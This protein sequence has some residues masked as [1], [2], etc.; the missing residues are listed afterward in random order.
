MVCRSRAKFESG[1]V[2]PRQKLRFE[3]KRLTAM[4]ARIAIQLEPC[5]PNG[6]HAAATSWQY[7][8]VYERNSFRFKQLDRVARH[9]ELLGANW[10][11]SSD[12]QNR[13]RPHL[14]FLRATRR[15]QSGCGTL[16]DTE[17]QKTLHGKNTRRKY[18][19]G[20]ARQLNDLPIE[21]AKN[22]P[23][24]RFAAHDGILIGPTVRR[25]LSAD[26][27]RAKAGAP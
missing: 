5:G 17:L 16:N 6:R 4:P 10:R 1:L 21:V 26:A 19:L 23:T 15:P 27:R 22:R 11:H 3:S 7:A 18:F 8:R 13:L 24:Q 14:E 12:M 20:H 25:G 9:C 2:T